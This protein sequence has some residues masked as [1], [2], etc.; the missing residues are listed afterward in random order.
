MRQKD[1]PWHPVTDPV[2]LKYLGKL[3]EECGELSA[4]VARC[5]IQGVD[6]TEPDT[7]V[8]NR[9]ALENEIA[10]ATANMILVSKKLGLSRDRIAER[11][12]LKIQRLEAWHDQA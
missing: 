12:N 6:G 8:L 2:L 10:D 3:A 4:I 1:D 11:S 9:T 7:G 5:I